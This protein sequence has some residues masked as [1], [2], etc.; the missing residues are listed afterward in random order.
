[1]CH[2]SCIEFHA[3]TMKS[4]M[5]NKFSL[6]EEALL[7]TGDFRKILPEVSSGSMAQI[8]KACVKSSFL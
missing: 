8:F 6:A 4:I 3:R 7:F 5:K 2:R 1:M